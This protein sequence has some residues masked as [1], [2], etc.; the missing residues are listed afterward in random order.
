MSS[1]PLET[2]LEL[3][4]EERFDY[5]L[6]NVLEEREIW[7]LVNQDNHFLKIV[8]EDDGIA[9]LPVWPSAAFAAKYAEGADGLTP[10][11]LSLPEFFKKWV[12]G[13]QKDGLE[14]GVFP[15]TDDTLWI[16][17]AADLKNDLQDE[18]ANI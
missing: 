11:N 2:I 7:I 15:G 16:T 6:D 12:P 14:V 9:Y 13:L 3:D 8:S 10:R 5:F 17:P 4:G 1:E 18:L